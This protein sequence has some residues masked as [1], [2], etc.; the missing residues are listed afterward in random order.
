MI[1]S[2]RTSGAFL[3]AFCDEA[4]TGSPSKMAEMLYFAARK[5]IAPQTEHF[6][7]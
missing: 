6:L 7:M 5:N 4:D 2:P 3:R 1:P